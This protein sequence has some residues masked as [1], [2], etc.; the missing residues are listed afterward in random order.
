LVVG[1]TDHFEGLVASEECRLDDYGSI[2][3]VRPAEE[4]AQKAT[5]EVPRRKARNGTPTLWV[6]IDS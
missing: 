1:L 2:L 3:C 6:D 4:A 5:D